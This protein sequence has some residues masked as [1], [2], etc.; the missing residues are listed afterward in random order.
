MKATYNG[1]ALHSI[2]NVSLTEESSTFTPAD[3]PQVETVTLRLRIDAWKRN[4]ADNRELMTQVKTAIKTQNGILLLAQPRIPGDDSGGD[5]TLYNQMATVTEDTFP[6]DMN[7]WGTTHQQI[8]ITFTVNKHDLTTN[9]SVLTIT[10]LSGSSITLNNVFKWKET[11]RVK[12]D[13]ELHDTREYAGGTIAASGEIL[14][15]MAQTLGD[16][17]TALMTLKESLFTGLN[18]KNARLQYLGFDK[19]ARI[20]D[21]DID[22]DQA[23]TK[24]VFSFTAIFTRFPNESGYARVEYEAGVKT[25]TDGED[26]LSFSGRIISTTEMRA[27][28]KLAAV[29]SAVLSANNFTSGQV[30]SAETKVKNV[31]TDSDGTAGGSADPITFIELSFTYSYTK[32]D[33][34]HM[35]Y[36]ITWDDKDEDAQGIITRTYSGKVTCGYTATAGSGGVGSSNNDLAYSIAVKQARLLGENKHTFRV[37]ASIKRDDRL[38]FRTGNIECVG[39]EFS[40]TYKFRGTRLYL[41]LKSETNTVTFGETTQQFS[42]FIVG[43]DVSAVATVY[44]ALKTELI[45]DLVRNETT[46]WNEERLANGTTPLAM[47][48][49]SIDEVFKFNASSGMTALK[50]RMDFSFQVIKDKATDWYSIKYGI[51]ISKNYTTCIRT[52]VVSG[53]VFGSQAIIEACQAETAGNKLDNLFSALALGTATERERTIDREYLP[54]VTANN[55]KSLK[56]DFSETFSQAIT[57]NDLIIECEVSEKIQFSG[58]RNIVIPLPDQESKVQ[59]MGI[60]EG[61]RSVTGSVTAASETVALK[62]VKKQKSLPFRTAVTGLEAPAV[63]ADEDRFAEP[64]KLDISNVFPPFTDGEVRGGDASKAPNIVKVNFDFT[65]I[66]PAYPYA[67]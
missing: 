10:P 65:E 31:G 21:L 16:R 55:G 30:V 24:L 20:T 64:I 14:G 61:R 38:T 35:S 54:G 58:N 36:T 40:F 47:A 33:P 57:G 56:L 50:H 66:I 28:A 59:Q 13:S 3:S 34:D 32:R 43:G 12:R 37:S 62:W 4:Y 17:R 8:R 7:E 9:A 46:S 63:P 41:E 67:L 51:R 52:I 39:V 11:L 29:L 44:A 27:R 19:T 45:T 26:V 5:L 2:G 60:V 1:V 42:G 22:I 18:Q 23:N 53:S 15:N 6:S 25:G 48:S 49:I